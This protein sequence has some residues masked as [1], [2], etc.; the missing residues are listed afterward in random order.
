VGGHQHHLQEHD[1]SG[2]VLLLPFSQG[3]GAVGSGVRGRTSNVEWWRL[4]DIVNPLKRM[5]MP[6]EAIVESR[7][8]VVVILEG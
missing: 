8:E 6:N 1:F 3:C 2:V 7:V 5:T 4:S